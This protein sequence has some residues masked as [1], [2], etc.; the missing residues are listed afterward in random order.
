MS[1]PPSV[2][3]PVHERI[4]PFPHVTIRMRRSFEA[5]HVGFLVCS[6]VRETFKSEAKRKL[7]EVQRLKQN[8]NKA[9]NN[10]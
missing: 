2:H 8:Q 5:K 3:V 1:I 4:L 7:K 9:K 6:H 10:M